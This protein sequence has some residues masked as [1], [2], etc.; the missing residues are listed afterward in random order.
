MERENDLLTRIV[1]VPGLCGGAAVVRGMRW[2]VYV[3]LGLLASGATW[4]EVVEDHPELD[5]DD[6]RACLAYASRL[7][8]TE[9]RLERELT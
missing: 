8:L 5:E 2:P 4:E 6:I 9:Y 3:V 7:S 1:K